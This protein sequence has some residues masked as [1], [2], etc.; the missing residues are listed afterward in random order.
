MLL[1]KKE[2]EELVVKS[3]QENKTIRQ[4]AEL[5][6][7]SFKDIGAVIRRIDGIANDS[8]DTNMRN[9]SKTTQTMF[10]LKLPRNQLML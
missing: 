3:H 7:M 10:L 2:K 5:V 8:V 6:H 1:N 9:R 4:M